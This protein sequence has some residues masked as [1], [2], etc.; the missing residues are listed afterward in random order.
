[1]DM[2]AYVL[3]ISGS[4][5]SGGAGMQADNRAILA[6]GAYPLNVLTAVTLQTPDGVEA[7]DVL[8]PEFVERQL[9]S[10]LRAYPVAAVKS[11]ML[12]SGAVAQAVAA[13]LSGVAPI[14]YVLDPVLCA[15]SGAALLDAEGL[16]VVRDRLLGRAVLTT[17]NLDELAVLSGRPLLDAAHMADAAVALACRSGGAVLVK[18]GHGHGPCCVD[19]LFWPDGRCEVFAGSRIDSTNTRGTGCALSALI[20]A[21][22]ALGDELVAAVAT[23]RRLLG[24]SLRAQAGR[25][26][27][28]PG[29][30]MLSTGENG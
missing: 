23:A 21:R 2:P 7:V 25:A 15:T 4:D 18:G 1:M 20:A 22:L 6:A 30:A 29:P 19:R 17:P 26:W 14:P 10:L 9:R 13:V 16:A 5:S 27:T 28:G 8:S 24:A 3:T 12:G 11:G